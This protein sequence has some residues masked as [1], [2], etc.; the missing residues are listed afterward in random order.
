MQLDIV[1]LEIQQSTPQSID[2]DGDIAPHCRYD[3]SRFLMFFK[4]LSMCLFGPD[5]EPAGPLANAIPLP[6]PA[7]GEKPNPMKEPRHSVRR[8]SGV[9]RR[10]PDHELRQQLEF[11]QGHLS[12]L[13]RTN[14]QS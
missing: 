5:A 11:G 1:S 13:G 7:A 10:L 14:V 4:Y 2:T 8:Y 6:L 3:S 9:C 12:N